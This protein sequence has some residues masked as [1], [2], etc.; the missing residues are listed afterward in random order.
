MKQILFRMRFSINLW[1]SVISFQL[2]NF[3]KWKLEWEALC[4]TQSSRVKSTFLQDSQPGNGAT[5]KQ[6]LVRCGLMSQHIPWSW[7]PENQD[8]A[9]SCKESCC[10]APVQWQHCP[11]HVSGWGDHYQQ[12][13][14]IQ[15]HLGVLPIASSDDC[16]HLQG[17]CFRSKLLS[18]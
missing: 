6:P 14:T 4:I 5:E 9:G 7:P 2:K 18:L 15:K 12:N 3:S 17:L 13:P 8:H 10:W 1:I 16:C 11:S